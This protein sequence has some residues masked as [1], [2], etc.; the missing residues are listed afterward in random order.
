MAKKENDPYTGLA[1]IIGIIAAPFVW[2]YQ[3]LGDVGFW[4]VIVG[5]PVLWIAYLIYRAKKQTKAINKTVPSSS[6]L[7]DD[8]VISIETISPGSG[9]NRKPNDDIELEGYIRIIGERIDRSDWDGARQML[10]SVA[11]LSTSAP[12]W[13]KIKW[14][15]LTARFAERDPLIIQNFPDVE[16]I[17]SDSPGIL[18]SKIY[19]FF[20]HLTTDEMRYI[21]YFA[22]VNESIL[23]MRKGTS[24]QLFAKSS[25]I[26]QHSN[27]ESRVDQFSP[28]HWQM[29]NDL[30]MRKWIP[31][32]LHTYWNKHFDDPQAAFMELVSEGYFEK[33]SDS[34]I[35]EYAFTK[36]ELTSLLRE[37]SMPV[38]GKKADLVERVLSKPMQPIE[39]KL[40]E[41]RL[42]KPARKPERYVRD[43]D[44]H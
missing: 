19:G 36:D 1:I 23:R 27:I 18:Q 44:F 21:L 33:A 25:M 26:G 17:I 15:D 34:E 24:Y 32:P 3:K 10:R 42:Y 31:L 14:R 28:A 39:L 11:Y 12:M 5:I 37:H 16:R 2:L 20:P 8:I 7:N 35:I 40:G 43:L 29:V 9:I 38:S 13:F 41:L 30:H 4:L 6:K 22:E